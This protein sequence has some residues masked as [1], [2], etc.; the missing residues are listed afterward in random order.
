M[1]IQKR[2]KK[3]FERKRRREIREVVKKANKN[4]VLSEKDREFLGK[5]L[6]SG[7][8]EAVHNGGE[9][10]LVIVLLNKGVKRKT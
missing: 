2:F 10:R 3:F 9:V 7:E 4:E 6:E 8:V 1:K 5:L